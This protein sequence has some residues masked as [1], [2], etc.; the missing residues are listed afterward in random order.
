MFLPLNKKQQGI[1]LIIVLLFMQML[2]MLSWYALN[3]VLFSVKS[4]NNQIQENLLLNSALEVLQKIEIA[5]VAELP[6]CL[7]APTTMTELQSKSEKWWQSTLT[8]AGIFQEFKYYYVV[9]PLDPD[10]CAN[11]EHSK[12]A[13]AYF[14]LTLFFSSSLDKTRLFLQSTLVR[15][16]SV[17][18]TCQSAQHVVKLGRQSWRKLD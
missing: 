6:A 3:N 11:V 2:A 17:Q 13:A 9:E 4:V 7:I 15:P 10:P 16:N 14:R 1:A 18:L 5:S 8:C 12:V